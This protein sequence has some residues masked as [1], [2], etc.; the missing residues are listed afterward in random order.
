MY[1]TLIWFWSNIQRHCISASVRYSICSNTVAYIHNKVGASLCSIRDW[2]YSIL[3][4]W[5]FLIPIQSVHLSPHWNELTTPELD[6]DEKQPRSNMASL[7]CSSQLLI[8]GMVTWLQTKGHHVNIIARQFRGV[9]FH[10][11]WPVSRYI[12]NIFWVHMISAFCNTNS[13]FVTPLS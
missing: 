2:K 8:I 4:Y 7:V 10:L 9:W 6:G 12:C 1:S 5:V 11:V 3:R 13:I